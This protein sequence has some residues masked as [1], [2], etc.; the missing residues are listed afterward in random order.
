MV[1]AF[2]APV[3]SPTFGVFHLALDSWT[4]RNGNRVDIERDDDGIPFGIRHSG[5]YYL[6]VDTQGPRIT[7]LRLL[8]EPPSRY[9]RDTPPDQGILVMRYGY[10]TA[11]NLTEVINSSDKPLCFTYDTDGRVTRWT[12]RN[13]TWFSY[14]Y[15]HRGRVVRTEGVDGILSGT[16]TY[17]DTART[18][19]YTD[20]QGHT[21][22]HRYNDNG[23]V[24]EETDALGHVTRT[25]W[26]EQGDKPLTVTDALGHITRYVYDG[27][28]N[29]AELVLPDGSVTRAAHDALG[30]PTE[31][32]E[33]GGAVWRHTYDERGNLL[34][35]V[36]PTGP[37]AGTRMGGRVARPRSQTPWV[38]PAQWP[39]T[40]RV[41]RIP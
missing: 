12:D 39:S 1:R 32:V 24:M 40:L 26:D 6:A 18:T 27:A 22:G 5:G 34:G 3:P 15:D 28:G 31:V 19:A 16:L 41:C 13:S 10:D 8:D 20:S 29:P 23:L 33:P 21:S 4:D 2:A 14:V 30:L 11:G 17:D 9:H 36:D 7:A 37:R 25:E 38:A 35:T